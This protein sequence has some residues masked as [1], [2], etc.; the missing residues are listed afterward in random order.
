MEIEIFDSKTSKILGI[1][2]LS[3]TA[4]IE[5]L[6]KRFASERPKYYV[7]RQAFRLE[8]RGRNLK[9]DMLLSEM[10][11]KKL[12]FRDLGPQVNWTVVFL[13]EY[14]GP[15]FAY[16][17]FYFQPSCIYGVQSSEMKLPVQLAFGC[18][19]FHYIKR[20]LETIFIHRFSHGTMPI[21]NL[22]RNCG[23]YWGFAAFMSYFINHPLYTS[24]Y[25]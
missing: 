20:I 6:K 2:K 15:I 24:A 1:Y 19:T 23:Y 17:L 16:A 5:D 22:F 7:D 4:K 21:M 13:A 8:P 14:S 12:F 3:I 25:F 11:E 18:F 9:D 10:K